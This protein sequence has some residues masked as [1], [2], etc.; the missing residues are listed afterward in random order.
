MNIIEFPWGHHGHTTWGTI[1][2]PNVQSDQS[3]VNIYLED[4]LVF[5]HDHNT[6]SIVPHLRSMAQRVWGR[7]YHG[8][9]L[10]IFYQ[11]P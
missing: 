10:D 4:E 3:S 8:H 9:F 11:D 6:L 1:L 7:A 2:T 5:Q